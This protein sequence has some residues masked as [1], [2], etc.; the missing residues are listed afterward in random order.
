MLPLSVMAPML[1]APVVSLQPV[2]G[3]C[4]VGME[5]VLRYRDNRCACQSWSDEQ[6]DVMP[7]WHRRAVRPGRHRL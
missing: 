4:Y 7:R 2:A 6:G 3:E 1:P 5:S